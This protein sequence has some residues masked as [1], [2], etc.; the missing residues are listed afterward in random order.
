MTEILP[1]PFPA[2]PQTT[3]AGLVGLVDAYLES[4]RRRDPTV[5]DLS[6]LVRF[7]ENGQVLVP[8]QGTW[9]TVR[10]VADE[11][12]VLVVD[13]AAGSVVAFTWI[14]EVA[15]PMLLVSRLGVC[16]G[17]I[18]ELETIVSRGTYTGRRWSNVPR[19]SLERRVIF[20]E[21]GAADRRS[22]RWEL[23]DAATRYLDGIERGD[24]AMIPV[25]EECRRLENGIVAARNLTGEGMPTFVSKDTL[26]MS[27]ADQISFGAVSQVV[28]LARERRFAAI[29]EERGSVV[30]FFFFDHRQRGSIAHPNSLYAGEAFKVVDGKIV[31]IEAGWE[32]VPFGMPSG[33]GW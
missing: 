30:A 20:D 10:Q 6:R 3:R 9:T 32:I 28:Q 33:W 26:A 8:G 11:P 16:G 18:R 15:S 1:M 21:G 29:D 12:A 24:G 22:S 31:H 14:H 19:A 7:T 2:R 4:L 25:T 27:V 5:L 17:R 23:A 13:E